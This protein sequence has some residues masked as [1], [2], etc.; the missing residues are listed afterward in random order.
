MLHIFKV[1]NFKKILILALIFLLPFGASSGK[2]AE[3]N[4]IDRTQRV[5]FS[6]NGHVRSRIIEEVNRSKY[7]IDIAVF[8]FT[9]TGIRSALRKAFKRGVRIRVVADKRES[10]DFHSAIGSLIRDGI[11]V[12]LIQ[13]KGRNGLMHHKF[14]VF[15]HEILLTGSYN[16][17]ETAERYSYENALFLRDKTLIND[18]QKEFDLLW[19]KA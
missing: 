8:N 15:D 3:N 1:V 12:K 16:W 2:S 5:Y 14:A 13:G 9:S 19:G 6:P 11:A 10:E 4:E 18:Y 7:S 17:T